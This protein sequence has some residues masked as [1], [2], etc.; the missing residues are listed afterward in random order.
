MQPA[1]LGSGNGL[2]RIL[3][4]L[5]RSIHSSDMRLNRSRFRT[6]NTRLPTG[7]DLEQKIPAYPLQ[8]PLSIFGS[9]HKL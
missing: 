3:K 7:P 2:E 4:D 8:D 9:L 1:M 6:G 5:P